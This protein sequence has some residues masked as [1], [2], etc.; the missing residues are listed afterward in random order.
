MLRP[1]DGRDVLSPGGVFMKSKFA[2]AA[3]I[4]IASA[5]FGAAPPASAAIVDVTYTGIV[6]QGTDETG[7]FGPPD[8]GLTYSDYLNDP[9]VANFMFDT[10]LGYT[11]NGTNPND[12][13]GGSGTSYSNPAISASV[14]I[15]GITVQINPNYGEINGFNNGSNSGQIDYV[16][17][18]TAYLSAEFLASDTSIPGSITTPLSYSLV[19]LLVPDPTV[20]SGYVNFTSGNAASGPYTQVFSNVQTFTVTVSGTP[21]PSA[22]LLLFSGFLGFGFF[23]YRGSKKNTAAV[24]A[25]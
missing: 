7:V 11:T 22:W 12:D 13:T 6:T 20:Y 8:T 23:A 19:P 5:L 17:N 4:L 2:G 10:S 18:N 14:T 9:L 24:A 15:N 25:A 3:T 16:S 1:K 21:L